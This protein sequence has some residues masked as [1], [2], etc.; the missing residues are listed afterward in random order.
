MKIKITHST[1]YKYSSMVPRLI[2]SLKLYPSICDNQEILEWETSSISGKI[3]ESHIDG[4]GHRVQNIFIHHS[5]FFL[6]SRSLFI[7]F[8]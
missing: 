5:Y 7:K 1:T 4:L 3:V 2:Q 8:R 6:G